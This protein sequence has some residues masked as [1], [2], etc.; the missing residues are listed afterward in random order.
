MREKP[1]GVANLLD[2][3]GSGISGRT[4]I[5]D[6]SDLISP[7]KHALVDFEMRGGGQLK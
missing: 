3:L 4:E 7:G 5:G 6:L 2:T 1:V